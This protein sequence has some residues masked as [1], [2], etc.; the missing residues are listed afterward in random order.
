VRDLNSDGVNDLVLF[1]NSHLRIDLL[2]HRRRFG[3][4]PAEASPISVDEV[5]GDWRFERKT[6]PLVKQ[7]A[8][9]AVGDFNGDGRTDIACFGVPDQLI[10]YF[11]PSSGEWGEHTTITVPDVP[12]VQWSM[13]AGDVN[14]DGKDDLVILGRQRTYVFLQQPVR[15]ITA[16]ILLTSTSEKLSLAQIVDLN[17]DGRKDLCYLGGQ[18]MCARLQYESGVLGPELQFEIDR[19]RAVSYAEIDGRPGREVLVIDAQTGRLRILQLQIPAAGKGAPTMNVLATFESKLKDT[20]FSDVVAGDLDG[21]GRPDL[22]LIDTRSHYV[23]VLNLDAGYQPHHAFHFKVLEESTFSKGRLGANDPRE[24][25][26][27]DVTGDGRNDIILL[28]QDRV[29]VYP[30]DDAK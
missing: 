8:S 21:H 4:S 28:A 16:P 23:E 19:P 24:A 15:G 26:I 14:G 30:H 9:M 29:L 12:P 5:N 22:A 7:L 2:L 20:F 17:G 25:Q 13:A 27:A 6:I 10:I 11:Q 1:D 18:H 3:A